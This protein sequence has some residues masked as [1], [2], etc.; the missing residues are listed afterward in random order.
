MREFTRMLFFCFL[1]RKI[2]YVCVYTYGVYLVLLLLYGR[3]PCNVLCWTVEENYLNYNHARIHLFGFLLD[4]FFF[5]AASSA[6]FWWEML[7]TGLLLGTF[8]EN[9]MVEFWIDKACFVIFSG[10][11]FQRRNK[12]PRMLHLRSN[13]CLQLL[14]S[15]K[16]RALELLQIASSK[17]MTKWMGNQIIL[18]RK[19]SDQSAIIIC[20]FW[21]Q[22]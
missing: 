12:L 22:F 13:W 15:L 6:L 9:I 20:N 21:W 2:F 14:V 16:Y 11:N 1:C 7:H 3:Q 17:A 8:I 5:F 4:F 18:V 19:Y 10:G